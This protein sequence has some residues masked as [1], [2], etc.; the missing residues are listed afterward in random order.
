MP[1]KIVSLSAMRIPINC[2]AQFLLKM[3]FMVLPTF[4]VIALCIGS[5][6]AQSVQ[7]YVTTVHWCVDKEHIKRLRNYPCGPDERDIDPLTFRSTIVTFD[8]AGSTA[9]KVPTGG[10]SADKSAEFRKNSQQAYKARV[11]ACG[12]KPEQIRANYSKD[13]SGKR[14]TD[15]I[16]AFHKADDAYRSCT[17]AAAI[18]RE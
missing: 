7:S 1:K 12:P 16:A 3:A 9:A 5:A 2:I 8:N 17:T 14:Q 15:D 10:F 11:D 6:A 13:P 4:A 18:A